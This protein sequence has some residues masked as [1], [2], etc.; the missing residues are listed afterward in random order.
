MKSTIRLTAF[1]IVVTLS[2]A[3]ASRSSFAGTTGAQNAKTCYFVRN[4]LPCP[5]PKAQ[6]ARAVAHAARS[7]VGAL[8]NAIGKTAVALSK[9]SNR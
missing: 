3:A 6:Q 7:T 2:L 1:A 9:A 5:C 8:G 4:H